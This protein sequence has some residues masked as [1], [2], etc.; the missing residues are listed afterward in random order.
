MTQ[1]KTEELSDEAIYILCCLSDIPLLCEGK[2]KL[3]AV[4]HGMKYI[5]C[6]TTSRQSSQGIHQNPFCN[7]ISTPHLESRVVAYQYEGHYAS[8]AAGSGFC[9]LSLSL[10]PFIGHLVVQMPSQLP[11]VCRLRLFRRSHR[12]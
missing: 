5:N 6:R 7:L 8:D 11:L 2:A 10:V 1:S 12:L 9:R 4:A 3:I